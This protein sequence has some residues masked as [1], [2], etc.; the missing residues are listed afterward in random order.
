MCRADLEP[1]AREAVSRL[2]TDIAQ[3]L[4]QENV[5]VTRVRIGPVD[6]GGPDRSEIT[7]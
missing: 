5:E 6:F 3:S 7:A 4:D 2:L 1:Q